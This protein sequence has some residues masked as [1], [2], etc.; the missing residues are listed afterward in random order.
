MAISSGPGRLVQHGAHQFASGRLAAFH[1]LRKSRLLALLCL[2]AWSCCPLETVAAGVNTAHPSLAYRSQSPE[3][4]PPE[5]DPV[6]W[7]VRNFLKSLQAG[8]PDYRDM[9][10]K[11]A[12]LLAEQMPAVQQE[13]QS[14]GVMKSIS[15]MRE[16]RLERVYEL[17]FDKGRM[18][19]GVH[20]SASGQIDSMRQSLRQY[21]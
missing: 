9:A 3:Q 12:A 18:I 20:Q 16:N 15:L 10:P 5:T 11:L 4:L 2:C 19:L 6:A 13:M 14:L 8:T 7:R 1:S 17:W 21:R